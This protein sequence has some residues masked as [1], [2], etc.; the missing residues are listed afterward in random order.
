MRDSFD[1]LGAMPA[2]GCGDEECE[3][4]R[5]PGAS[6]LP[7]QPPKPPHVEPTAAPEGAA[8]GSGAAGGVGRIEDLSDTFWQIAWLEKPGLDDSSADDS[9][10]ENSDVDS[11]GDEWRGEPY[12]HPKVIYSCFPVGGR[13][14]RRPCAEL[15]AAARRERV[16]NARGQMLRCVRLD[17]ADAHRSAC[18]DPSAK[19]ALGPVV[20]HFHG[21]AET[22]RECGSCDALWGELYRS[23]GVAAVLFV[24][25]RG[26]A[27]TGGRPS[28]CEMQDD[29]LAIVAAAGVPTEELIFYGRSIGSVFALAAAAR[30]PAARGLVLESGIAH[31]AE[32]CT[33]CAGL[34]DLAWDGVAWRPRETAME[35]ATSEARWLDT[36]GRLRKYTGPLLV[37]HTRSDT[38]VPASNAEDFARMAEDGQPGRCR[39]VVW[40]SGGH[41]GIHIVNWEA[42]QR[43]LGAFVAATVA[44]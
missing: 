44:G 14:V 12:D 20:L 42:L 22:A 1:I 21:N 38:L 30:F 35:A 5:S 37:L 41:N 34:E 40:P 28:L 33:S 6:A 19:E 29:L 43:E 26:Y 13:V 7:A 27:G 39:L 25:Y 23:T 36:A 3:E 16:L 9:D 17:F 11:S 4:A 15:H 8:P 32:W 18:A 2:D 24:E 31:P 10:S